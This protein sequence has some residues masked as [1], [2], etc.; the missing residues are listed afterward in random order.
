M[1]GDMQGAPSQRPGY[2][3]ALYAADPDPWR[4]E[5]SGYEHAKY[6][7][8]VAALAEAAGPARLAHVL[9]VG[10]SIGVLTHR[11]A[12]VCGRLLGVD[13]AE[14][15]LAAA[16]RRCADRPHVRF[17]LSHLPDAAP[18]GPFDGVVLSEVLYY[19][20]EAELRRM[21]AVLRGQMAPG[22]VVVLVHWLGP[23]PDYPTTGDSAT[24]ALL[25]AWPDHRII[26]RQRRPEYRLDCVSLP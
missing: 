7:A 11:L 20:D 9:E 22:C 3:D 18:P 6:A 8:T 14:A 4:F 23:T 17:A 26:Q 5:T 21:A 15:A 10:C 13:V 25:D 12:E 24:A 16:R 1:T 2:F 19:F